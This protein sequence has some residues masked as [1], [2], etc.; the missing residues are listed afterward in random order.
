MQIRTD[1]AIESGEISADLPKGV[2][3]NEEVKGSAKITRIIIENKE[4]EAALSRPM[5]RYVTVEVPA[6]SD[7]INGEETANL[8]ANE[9]EKLIPKS[10]TV[11]VVGLGNKTITPDALGPAVCDRVLATRHIEKEILRKS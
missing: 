1:L 3:C 7:G 6:L 4:G 11:L 8:V 10:G 9:L 2:T 5:G